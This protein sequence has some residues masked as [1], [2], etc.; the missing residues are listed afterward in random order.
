MSFRVST[1]QL[2]AANG[3]VRCGSC[4]GVFSASANEIRVKHPDGYIVEELDSIDAQEDDTVALEEEHVEPAAEEIPEDFADPTTSTIAEDAVAVGTNAEGEE[5]QEDGWHDDEPSISLGDMRLDE[6]LDTDE[7]ED[8][9][10]DAD[11]IAEYERDIPADAADVDSTEDDEFDAGIFERAPAAAVVEAVIKHTAIFEVRE[12][13][14]EKSASAV[15]DFEPELS[16]QDEFSQEESEDEAPVL[17]DPEDADEHAPFSEFNDTSPVM[18]AESADSDEHEEEEEAQALDE[19]AIYRHTPPPL[20][21]RAR[22]IADKYELHAHLSDLTDDDALDPLD[23]NARLDS[24]E[25]LPVTIDGSSDFRHRLTQAALLL[26]SILLLLALPAP[27]LYTHKDDLSTHPRFSFM[28]PLVCKVLTCEPV[29]TGAVTSLYSQQLLVRSHPRFENALEVSFVFHNDSTLPQPF[30]N[31]EL[32]FSDVDNK[33]LA[34]RLF[35]PQEYLPPEL[36]QLRDMPASSSVQVALEVAD[37]GE[38]AVNYT[39]KLHTP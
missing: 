24:L 27:W 22:P 8:S 2:N 14:A 18:R 36:R 32:A 3:L 26:A 12:V 37:P 25:D 21:T 10:A 15:A 13:A 23:A 35:T 6:D 38:E 19:I 5:D 1:A 16:S 34:N 9:V 17:E 30:P 20:S 28:A 31:L 39:V 4:L 33:L 29:A 7:E 11:T